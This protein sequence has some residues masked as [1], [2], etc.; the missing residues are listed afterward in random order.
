MSWMLPF[1]LAQ[2]F[3][4]MPIQR[5]QLTQSFS[6]LLLGATLSTLSTLN[7]SLALLIGLLCSPLNFIRPLPS[8]PPRSAIKSTADG[9]EYL[10][11]LA[12]IL[13]STVLYLGIS[14]PIV[15]YA[16]SGWLGR[17]VGWMLGELAKGW[18]AQGVWSS[19]VIWGVWWPAWVVGGSVLW[20]GLMRK[21]SR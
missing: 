5:I 19:L 18:V 21:G 1:Y 16:V 12:L 3:A 13:P 8:L 2:Q 7:F 14:P 11:N 10:N 9:S 15:L 4:K 20:S 17:V 6:L